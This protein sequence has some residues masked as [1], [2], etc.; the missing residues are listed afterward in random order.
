M[1]SSE[2]ARTGCRMLLLGVLGALS[3][4]T[5]C[6]SQAPQPALIVA[7][8]ARTSAQLSEAANRLLGAGK[9]TLAPEAFTKRS[10]LSFA[11]AIRNTPKGRLATGRVVQLPREL[12]LLRIGRRCELQNVKNQRTEKLPGVRCKADPG[13]AT[14]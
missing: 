10:T 9:V 6:M 11:P 4:S 14:D 12:R 13:A 2:P 3:A 7:P 1:Q 5:G 8:D